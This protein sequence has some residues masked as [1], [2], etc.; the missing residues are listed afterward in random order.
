M[1]RRPR[2]VPAGARLT[3]LLAALLAATT[4]GSV[5]AESSASVS[6]SV[7]VAAAV[8]SVSLTVS[9]GSIR[10]GDSVRAIATVSNTGT[11]RATK[12]LVSLRVDSAGLRVK[13]T[14]PVTISGLQPGHPKAASWS[15][16]GLQAGNY[17]LLARVTIDGASVDSPAVLLSV[18]GQRKKAC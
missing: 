13:G 1:N 18:A 16:C 15:V 6:A 17:V 12:V 5:S 14:N 10:V 7:T 8:V 4:A 9:S 11:G 2:A 3:T